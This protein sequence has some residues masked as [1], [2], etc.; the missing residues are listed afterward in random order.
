MVVGA[1]FITHDVE[2]VCTRVCLVTI[3]Q[4]PPTSASWVL[5]ASKS[6]LR[7][8]GVERTP[9]RLHRGRKRG[10]PSVRHAIA[11]ALS[12]EGVPRPG[13]GRTAQTRLPLVPN[14]NGWV[15]E[16]EAVSDT[17]MAATEFPGVPV[18]SADG[19]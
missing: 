7:A 12:A 13:G 17:L 19:P 15:C 18:E 8:E 1:W 6:D 2:V 16:K 5:P 11:L 9:V 4:D 3:N 14:D 10:L